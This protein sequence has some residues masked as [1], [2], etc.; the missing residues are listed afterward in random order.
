MNASTHGGALQSL[1]A[2]LKACPTQDNRYTQKLL[3][4]T[5]AGLKQVALDR[6]DPLT[7]S[8]I[9][10]LVLYDDEQFAELLDEAEH[11]QLTALAQK[12]LERFNEQSHPHNPIGKLIAASL[13]GTQ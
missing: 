9:A 8:I 7:P 13:K 2:Q 10:A 4:E 3:V 1:A 5:W 6:G 11:E 12:A